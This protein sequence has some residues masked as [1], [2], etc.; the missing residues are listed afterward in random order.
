MLT[1]IAT[2]DCNAPVSYMAS[3]TDNCTGATL[4]YAPAAGSTFAVGTSV[5][6]AT[7]TDVGGNTAT[8]TFTVT[9]ND[10]EAPSAICQNVLIELGADYGQGFALGRPKPLVEPD[11]AD[12]PDQ[13]KS[14]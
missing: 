3:V 12:L 14:A 1:V 9:V 11:A 6:T 10:T 13:Q 5:V 2:G 8:C 7:A 4:A